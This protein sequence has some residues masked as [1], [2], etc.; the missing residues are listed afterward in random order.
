MCSPATSEN[1]WPPAHVDF[2][3]PISHSFASP[4]HLR[5]EVVVARQVCNFR[6]PYVCNFG[7]PLTV[8]NWPEYEAGEVG[9]SLG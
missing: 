9:P 4:H 3:T 2:G 1:A 5:V 7:R 6:W 8:R